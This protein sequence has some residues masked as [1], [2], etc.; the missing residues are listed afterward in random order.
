MVTILVGHNEPFNML[1]NT[2]DYKEKI[3]DANLGFSSH[4]IQYFETITIDWLLNAY[5]KIMDCNEMTKSLEYHPKFNN[6][7]IQCR[8]ISYKSSPDN[9]NETGPR[10]FKVAAFDTAK[11]KSIQKT[12]N[13]AC[14]DIF[15]KPDVEK[16]KQRPQ[17][18]T[19]YYC[20]YQGEYKCL[21]VNLETQ[22]T[23]E[24][25]VVKQKRFMKYCKKVQIKGVEGMDKL[26]EISDKNTG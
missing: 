13:A 15:N 23:I 8:I 4:D 3:H 18:S 2:G 14:K 11:V 17:G 19:L 26:I 25:A 10:A 24:L 6:I 5:I 16:A 21:D 20:K 12:A 22:K 9:E 7:P 1:F